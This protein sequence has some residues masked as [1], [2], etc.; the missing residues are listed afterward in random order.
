MTTLIA[1]ATLPSRLKTLTEPVEVIDESGR[2]LG[3][4]QPDGIAASGI[5]AARSP[6][7]DEKLRELQKHS[8]ESSIRFRPRIALRS[9]GC[10]V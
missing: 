7:T 6:N 1:D 5:A 3:Y 9:S 4:Y 2:I 8:R 10:R